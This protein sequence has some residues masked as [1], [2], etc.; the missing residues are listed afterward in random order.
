[1]S[2]N[3]PRDK[4]I[5][6]WFRFKLPE[7]ILLDESLFHALHPTREEWAHA[8]YG[9]IKE[10]PQDCVLI[11]DWY[12][13]RSWLEFSQSDSYEELLSSLGSHSDIP[14]VSEI[15]DFA[16]D[17]PTIAMS[18]HT[19]LKRVYFPASISLETRKA[20]WDRV[21]HLGP[22][23]AY[24]KKFQHRNPYTLGPSLA[25]IE[26]NVK[27]E[28]QDAVSCVWIH[29]WKNQEAE[30]KLKTTQRYSH[31]KD[32]EFIKPLILDLFEQGLRDLG[33]LGWEECHV[34]F[35][36]TCYIP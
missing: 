22:S 7:D 29:K 3:P 20:V 16:R 8:C 13:T 34:N 6:T 19:E 9:R 12:R 17:H 11:V 35:E 27:W 21:R 4:P 10:S 15:I 25:W 32:G 33:A 2:D 30:E 24:G 5:T 23:V 36:T 14:A 1:M 18:S 31:M 26:G 28:G